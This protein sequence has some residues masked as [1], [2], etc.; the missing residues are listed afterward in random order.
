MLVG[1]ALLMVCTAPPPNVEPPSGQGWWWTK[2][3]VWSLRD[4]PNAPAPNGEVQVL[5]MGCPAVQP[6][7]AYSRETETKVR[8]DLAEANSLI[9]GLRLELK[10]SRDNL[11]GAAKK[12]LELVAKGDRILDKCVDMADLQSKALSEIET[13]RNWLKGTLALTVS[14]VLFSL[15]VFPRGE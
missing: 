15:L 9:A 2:D 6:T 3:C 10:T 1:I 4:C 13:Q 14:L 5:P 8:Q 12:S 11:R 7:I